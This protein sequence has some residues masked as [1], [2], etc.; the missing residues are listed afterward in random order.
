MV[1]SQSKQLQAFCIIVLTFSVSAVN[2]AGSSDWSAPSRPVTIQQ[3]AP[4]KLAAPTLMSKTSISLTVSFRGPADCGSKDGE[5]AFSY[6]LRYSDAPNRIADLLA[7]KENSSI[8]LVRDARP[9]GVE[10][11]GLRPGRECAMQVYAINEYGDAEFS[12]IAEYTT[13]AAPPEPPEAPRMIERTIYS[14]SFQIIP[15]RLWVAYYAFQNG[16]RG[17]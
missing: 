11:T 3:V 7:K 1:R 15:G 8:R 16:G 12:D 2:A 13:A 6:M 4:A 14:I 5:M 9:R 17:S 10:V